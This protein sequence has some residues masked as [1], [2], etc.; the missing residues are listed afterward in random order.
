MKL[1][2]WILK[3]RGSDLPLLLCAV[4]ERRALISH[5][6]TGFF[7]GLNGVSSS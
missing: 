4:A 2:E 3:R 6:I 1:D 5:Q 7:A